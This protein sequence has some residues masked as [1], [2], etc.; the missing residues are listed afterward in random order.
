M[1]EMEFRHVQKSFDQLEVLRDISFSVEKG[2]FIAIVGPSGCGKSTLLR[3]MAGLES[4]TKGEVLAVGQTVTSPSPQR[5]ML[6]Q[7]ASLFPW[8]TVERN[9]A[10]GL[11]MAGVPE[12]E[13]GEKVLYYLERV[14]LKDFRR[15]Y[16]AQLSGG[17]KQRVAIARAF[18]M[19]PEI[20]LMDE[21]YGALDA[22]TRISMQKELL[23]LWEG[24]GKTVL[25][26][27]HDVDEAVVLADRVIVMTSKPGRIIK[28]Q[29]IDIPRSRNRSDERFISH[30]REILELLGVE[31]G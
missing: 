29:M 17:M 7:E 30:R 1:I 14:G 16:P 21:P 23:S 22:L 6:F 3:M 8:L 13:R 19:D 10:F 4:P 2:E 15:Y 18:V 28:E 27:T 26:I 25:L 5:M 11:E 9:V 24:S 31:H 12:R 20:L